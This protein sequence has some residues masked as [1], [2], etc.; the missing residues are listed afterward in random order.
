MYSCNKEEHELHLSIVMGLMKKHSLLA[1][2]SKCTF[3]CRKV[4]YLGHVISEEGVATDEGKIEVVRNW[5]PPK[6]IK[7]VR[8]FL[9]LTGYYRRFVSHYGTIAKPLV[10]VIKGSVFRW[11]NEAQM[12]FEKLKSA[13]TS[14]PVLALPDFSK[15]FIVETDASGVGIGAVLMQEKHPIAYISKAL[16]PRYQSLSVYAGYFDGSKEMVSLSSVQEVRHPN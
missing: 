1:K 10:E 6:T 8:S 13:M 14:A 5:P 16:S 3:G 11:S 4:E 12:A 7:H 15:E 9:G 2:R